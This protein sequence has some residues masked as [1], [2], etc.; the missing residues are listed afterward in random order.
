MFDKQK[1]FQ[2][3]FY[4]G[5]YEMYFVCHIYVLQDTD[6]TFEQHLLSIYFDCCQFVSFSNSSTC[7]N[8]FTNIGTINLLLLIFI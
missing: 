8:L 1:A 4:G 3:L 5:F 7:D 6:M 2:T